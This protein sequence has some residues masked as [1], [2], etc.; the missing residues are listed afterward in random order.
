MA[1]DLTARRRARTWIALLAAVMC[2]VA[3][4][5]PKLQGHGLNRTMIYVSILFS[6]IAVIARRPRG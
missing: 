6:A 2:L 1:T 3:A 4:V 5:V